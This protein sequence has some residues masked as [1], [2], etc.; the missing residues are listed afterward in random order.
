M[1]NVLP[2][3]IACV[4]IS[5]LW[6]SSAYASQNSLLALVDERRARKVA[7]RLGVA[8]VGSGAIVAQLKRQ[9]LIHSVRPVL[10]SWQQHG[11]FVSGPVVRDIL[12][13]SGEL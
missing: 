7:A 3:K 12:R 9:G 1:P 8:V 5:L 11:Y 4:A 10:L 13:L 2:V 6:A